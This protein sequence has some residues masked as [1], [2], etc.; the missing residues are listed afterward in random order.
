MVTG[1]AAPAYTVCVHTLTHA[2]VDFRV[3]MSSFGNFFE[4]TLLR[5]TLPR[6]GMRVEAHMHDLAPPGNPHVCHL[7]QSR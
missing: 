2:H 4:V 7:V 1:T 6:G 3:H 5:S